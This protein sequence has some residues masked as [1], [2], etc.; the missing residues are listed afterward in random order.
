MHDHAVIEADADAIVFRQAFDRFGLPPDCIF[1]R[2]E[3]SDR[4]DRFGGEGWR[5]G[6]AG[7]PESVRS[8]ADM[9]ASRCVA[10]AMEV[11]VSPALF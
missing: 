11:S 8:A 2:S 7:L 4:Q 5:E 10:D 1:V 3:T 6:L 9:I